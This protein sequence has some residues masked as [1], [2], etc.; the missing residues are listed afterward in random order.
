MSESPVRKAV[1]LA[2]GLGTRMRAED[3]TATLDESQKA[4]ANIGLKTLVPIFEGKT[5]LDFIL[6]SVL[7]AGFTD[8]CLVIGDEHKEIRDFCAKKNHSISFA[9]QENPLG[10]ADAVRA[11]E[12]FAEGESFLVVNSDNLYPVSALK[13][14]RAVGVSGLVAFDR[15]ALVSESNIPAE[16]IANFAEVV[17][18]D[19]GYLKEIVEKP[20]NPRPQASVSM[21]AWLFTSKI[22][23]SCRLIGPSARGEFEITDAVA[24]AM[25]EFGEKFRAVPSSEGV[26]DLSSR[27][28]ISSVEKLLARYV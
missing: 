28:D 25:R 14:L 16:R 27:A 24:H 6:T 18:D 10:T 19:D 1:I 9:I 21:N 15:Q 22:F 20:S 11:A 12:N 3:P 7:D 13:A 8:I 5:L 2:R 23:D 4:V 26:L 17:L